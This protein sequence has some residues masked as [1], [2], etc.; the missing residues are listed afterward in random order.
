[1]PAAAIAELLPESAQPSRE[2]QG[3]LFEAALA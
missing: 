1:V 3:E 2:E